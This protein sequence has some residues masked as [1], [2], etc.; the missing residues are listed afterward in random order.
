MN[1]ECAPG[2]HLWAND[3]CRPHPL[4]SLTTTTPLQGKE[5]RRRPGLTRFDAVR[6]PRPAMP[7][8]HSRSRHQPRPPWWML[9]ATRWPAGLVPQGR[10]CFRGCWCGE[11]STRS[12]LAEHAPAVRGRMRGTP[13]G[14]P[15]RSLAA[16]LRP[17]LPGPHP[18]KSGAPMGALTVARGHHA[19]GLAAAVHHLIAGS[20]ARGLVGIAP[21][22]VLLVPVPEGR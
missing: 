4:A 20:T 2:Q 10:R 9:P 17:P 12:A 7:I 19:S 15:P 1:D 5:L 16:S 11:A 21:C 8:S 6:H 22:P 13:A 14:G 3:C 18:P